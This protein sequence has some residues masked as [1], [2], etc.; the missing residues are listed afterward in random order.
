MQIDGMILNADISDIIEI[1]RE[2][3][4]EQQRYLFAKT[5][6]SADD[7]MVCCPYHK[8]GQ[9]NNPSMGIRKSDGMCHCLACGETHSLSEMI[10]YCFDKD[11]IYGHK[12]L[13]TNFSADLEQPR[14]SIELNINRNGTEKPFY[15]QFSVSEE[16]LDSYRYFH[17]YMRER[18]LTDEI[19]EKFDIGYDKKSDSI[20]FPIR[21]FKT[22][23]CT[24]VARRKIAYKRFDIPKGIDK[25]L[26]GE[27]EIYKAQLVN[28][29]DRIKEVYV[30]EGLF[31][32][33]RLWCNGKYAVAGFGCLFSD[34][35]IHALENL[36]TR[37]LILALDNDIA[38]Q[39]AAEK[40]R[41]RVHNKI[42][43]N[44]VIPSNRKDI[45]ECTDD[46]IINLKEVI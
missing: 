9:E 15:T 6:D 33:L 13:I 42:I 44:A 4:A 10:G 35:Q 45:G 22:H 20:T 1:L 3:L 12:W 11:T 25:P 36:P 16:E 17:P 43:T 29:G 32:C 24:F 31:D 7:L 19:I 8:N 39:V 14:K 23:L 34:K 40:L 5:K 21:D 27:Y 30:C 37:K 28:G 38:G 18:G 41:K 46:E 26:Y 2:Q